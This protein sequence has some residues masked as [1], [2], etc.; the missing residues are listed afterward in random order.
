MED[1][2]FLRCE[3]AC[4]VARN[5]KTFKLRILDISHSTT[6]EPG[7]YISIVFPDCSGIRQQRSYTVIGKPEND[8]IVIAVQRTGRGGVSD[9][10][11]ADLKEGVVVGATGAA[12]EITSEAL[13]GASELVLLAGGIGITLPY[14]LIKSLSTLHDAGLPVP[15]TTL[16]LSAPDVTDIPFLGELLKLDM[17]TDW[18]SI[19]LFITR[20]PIRHSTV[21][22]RSGRIQASLLAEHAQ[23][24]TVIICGGHSF[25][26]SLH[27]QCNQVYERAHYLIESFSA[28]ETDEITNGR[29]HPVTLYIEGIDK[30]LVM[31]SDQSLLDGLEAHGIPIKTQCRTGVCGSCKIRINSGDIHRSADF[32]LRATERAAG[33]ALACCSFPQGKAVSISL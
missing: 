20:S 14:G 12:G 16:F 5:V 10:L 7:Q 28:P 33:Y 3:Q 1:I 6:P 9:R 23:P 18:F 22:F 11:H 2:M 32:A 31:Q 15:K 19:R 8:L 17:S 26:Q 13:I 21:Q 30:E 4:E 27:E 29:P 25:A 24:D